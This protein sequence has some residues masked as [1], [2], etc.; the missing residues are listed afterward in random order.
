[1]ARGARNGFKIG[2][3]KKSQNT[4]TRVTDNFFWRASH[5][6]A[7]GLIRRSTTT[8]L[9][10]LFAGRFSP[11]V[12]E[13]YSCIAGFDLTRPAKF[14]DH[15]LQP[16]LWAGEISPE[17]SNPQ[18]ARFSYFETRPGPSCEM[19]FSNPARRRTA[20]LF[21]FSNPAQPGSA[22]EMFRFSDPTRPCPRDFQHFKPGAA[23][24]RF[25]R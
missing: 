7:L 13:I 4:V 24:V 16:G 17:I 23:R 21:R 20:R 1:M 15:V 5:G 22:S 11:T 19:R 18:P 3:G 8:K 6:S 14:S 10:G 12:V 25:L 9:A 2:T